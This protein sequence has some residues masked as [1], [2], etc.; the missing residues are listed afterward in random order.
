MIGNNGFGGLKIKTLNFEAEI[1]RKKDVS[2]EKMIGN[3]IHTHTHTHMN[4]VRFKNDLGSSLVVQWLGIHLP[5][6][7]QRFDP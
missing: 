1:R 7:E 6:K 3:Y 5:M 2:Q 4:K